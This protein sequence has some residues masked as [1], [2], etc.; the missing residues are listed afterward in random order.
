MLTELSN[1]QD[2]NITVLL[3]KEFMMNQHRQLILPYIIQRLEIFSDM[4]L[5]FTIETISQIRQ[6]TIRV[7]NQNNKVLFDNQLI[8]FENT[9]FELIILEPK[10]EIIES[11]LKHYE[12]I[13]DQ[14]QCRIELQPKWYHLRKVS[15][16][17]KIERILDNYDKSSVC[18]NQ[19]SLS[20]EYYPKISD[21]KYNDFLSYISKIKTNHGQRFLIERLQ[22]RMLEQFNKL[23]EFCEQVNIVECDD[24]SWKYIILSYF[25]Y[26]TVVKA[27]FSVT[28]IQLNDFF[29]RYRYASP[30]HLTLEYHQGTEK[31][32]IGR[33]ELADVL[34]RFDSRD[35]LKTLKII[36]GRADREDLILELSAIYHSIANF[37]NLTK[38]NIPYCQDLST[39]RPL[40]QLLNTLSPRLEILKLRQYEFSSCLKQFESNQLINY[41]CD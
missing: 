38:L 10:E 13:L 7:A 4:V 28:R 23:P 17:L 18:L 29:A 24:S 3:P 15:F 6:L 30:S 5:K 25:I 16:R 40:Q 12:N 1:G 8:P 35:N 36:F 34:Q 11:A 21:T 33:I 41:A 37:P 2:L 9:S 14:Q 20:S 26:K 22:M 32:S 39:L 19:N 27:R 31:S